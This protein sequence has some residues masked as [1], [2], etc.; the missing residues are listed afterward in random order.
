MTE[1]NELVLLDFVGATAVVTL[2]RPQRYNSLVPA[3]LRH[4]LDAL[5]EVAADESVKA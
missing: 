4:M 3:L 5:A 2:N 1:A